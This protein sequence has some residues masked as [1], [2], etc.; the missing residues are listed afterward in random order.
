VF[1]VIKN[2]RATIALLLLSATLA[3]MAWS[4]TMDDELL[5]DPTQPLGMI[6]R[7]SD[8]D[9]SGE[10]GF[11]LGL[12]DVFTSYELSSVLI[13]SGYRV[14]I[15]NDERVRVG[16]RVGSAVVTSIESDHVTLNVDGEVRTLALYENSI[17]TRVK[18]DE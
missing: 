10:D 17:K 11:G 8:S 1:S 14:A 16:D 18:G 12:F 2:T 7:S 9:S 13:R 15:I 4:A 3:S 5:I 6:F